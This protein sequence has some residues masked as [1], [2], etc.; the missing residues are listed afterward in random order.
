[1][2][3]VVAKIPAWPA[4]LLIILV[5]MM[6]ADGAFAQQTSSDQSLPA[7]PEPKRS[8]AQSAQKP[9]ETRLQTTIDVL[10]RRSVFF[11]ELAYNKGPLVVHQKLELAVDTTITPSHFLGAL[12]TSGIS[13]AR[14]TLGYGEGWDAYG[15]RVGSSVASNA[16]SHL[17][18]TFFL[19]SVLHQDPRYFVKFHGNDLQR[20]GY[21][22]TRVVETRTDDGRE[23]FNWSFVGGGML[24][25]GLATV[26][27]PPS[28]RTVGKTFDRVGVR[29]TF[30]A[31]SNIVKEYWPDIFK[32]LKMAKMAPNQPPDPGTVTPQ[33]PATQH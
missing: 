10:A 2:A 9:E 21:A 4:R 23:V 7:A 27:L 8:Q 20:V 5:V 15:Q 29:M 32:S 18:G 16:T 11:P 6:A 19:P 24:A 28:Q 22:I 14:G 25:E 12:I 31:L 26:Y 33:V 1:M 13:Q 30:G 3:L 17:F